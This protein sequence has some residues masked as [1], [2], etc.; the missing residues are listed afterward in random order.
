MSTTNIPDLVSA[1]E[2]S[3]PMSIRASRM[4]KMLE[5]IR[6]HLEMEVAYLSE[7]VD[8]QSVFRAVDAPGLEE[9][10]HVGSSYPL[11]D[12]YC[13]HICEGRLPE[14]IP[15]TSDNEFALTIPI[16][17]ALPI[18]SHMSLPIKRPD[19]SLYGMFCCLS[20]K[21]NKTL[22]VRDLNT[23][24]VFADLA[25]EQIH[26][27]LNQEDDLRITKKRIEDIIENQSFRCV[28]QPIWNLVEGVPAGFEALCR[29]DGEPYRAP[30]IWFNEA[31]DCGMGE[32]LELAVIAQAVKAFDDLPENCYVS[33]NVSPGTV[34]SGGLAKTIGH[35]PLNRLVIEITEHAVV[36]DYQGLDEAL[37]PLRNAGA[38]LAVDDAGAGYSSLKHIVMLK[39]EII[40]LDMSL[41]RSI[42]SDQ[43]LR[44]LANALIHFSRETGAAIVAEGI[45]TEGEH[46]MLKMLGV[47][48]GQGYHLGR[49]GD[50]SSVLDLISNTK[51]VEAKAA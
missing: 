6:K 38:R 32:E 22:N 49:P 13:K 44:A 26:D 8:G 23:M 51:K 7:F 29:F 21:P 9:L 50:L 34:L 3:E 5:T 19:G 46:K 24:R 18:G 2:T 41:T 11:E 30:D 43:A 16:T 17:K 37:A 42:D 14:L 40:K 15:D 48:G 36:V 33:I 4:D 27:E 10:A 39:P 45:E 25:T 1:G 12:I 35:L 20:S 47:Y 28:Y 31:A